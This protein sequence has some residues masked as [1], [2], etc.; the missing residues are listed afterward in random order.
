MAFARRYPQKRHYNQTGQPRLVFRDNSLLLRPLTNCFT[1]GL[2]HADWH[3]DRQKHVGCILVK[4]VKVFLELI[5]IEIF[6][7][8]EDCIQFNLAEPQGA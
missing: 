8:L 3:F 2:L 7:W 5:P 4:F 6:F 1:H